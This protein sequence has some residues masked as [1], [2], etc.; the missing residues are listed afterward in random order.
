MQDVVQKVMTETQQAPQLD[1]KLIE[2]I[3]KKTVEET[4]EQ[5]SKRTSIDETIQIKIGDKT[6]GG[7][8]TVL[9]ENK[10]NEN[11]K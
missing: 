3:I 11:K 9:K 4:L 1:V 2:F 8:L 5:V 10:I 6:F 7:K